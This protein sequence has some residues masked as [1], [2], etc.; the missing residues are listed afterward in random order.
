MF[1]DVVR[2]I[3]RYRAMPEWEYSAKDREYLAGFDLEAY[4]FNRGHHV[5]PRDVLR[6]TLDGESVVLLHPMVA[7]RTGV[8][9]AQPSGIEHVDY[10]V[11]VITLPV[12]L[13]A[14]AAT[15]AKLASPFEARD[16]PALSSAAGPIHELPEG[17][18]SA[19]VRGVTTD[20]AFGE[21]VWTDEV[22]RLTAQAQ[23]GWRV[24][25]DRL[26]G[27]LGG[28]R[29][30]EDLLAAVGTLQGIRAAILAATGPQL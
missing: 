14:I 1:F 2:S 4:P 3:R 11:A 17:G 26:L 15:P 13:S 21:A 5:L 7:A 10:S 6:G 22:K 9:A 30:Y 19:A 27:W 8:R 29:T 12:A 18:K 25:G 23:I 20:L 24:D 16:L 28:R